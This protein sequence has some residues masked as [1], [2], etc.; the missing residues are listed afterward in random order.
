MAVTRQKNAFMVT[1]ATKSAKF[2]KQ[3]FAL[4]NDFNNFQISWNILKGNFKEQ[5]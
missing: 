1:I 4:S 2:E 5:K 3:I